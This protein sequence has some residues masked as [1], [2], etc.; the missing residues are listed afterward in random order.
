MANKGEPYKFGLEDS[1]T[2]VATFLDAAS[3]DAAAEGCQGGLRLEQCLGPRDMMATQ[4]PHVKWS[5]KRPPT[6]AF[7]SYAIA[8]KV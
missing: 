8:E 2:G 5:D 6:A 3:A 1:A 7:Y 4:L